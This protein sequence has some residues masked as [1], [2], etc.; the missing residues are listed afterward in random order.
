MKPQN[1]YIIDMYLYVYRSYFARL[2]KPLLSP[3]GE[4]TACVYVFLKT[5]FKL[6]KN[7]KPDMLVVAADSIGK[8]FRKEAYESYKGSRPETM[9]DD[10]IQQ[11][12][13]LIEILG[14]MDIPVFRKE[15]FEADDIIG[16]IVTEARR[17]DDGLALDLDKIYICTAD[18][19]MNQ[20]IVENK[21]LC[22]DM[23]RDTVT[24]PAS[25]IEKY[26]IEPYQFIE[27]LALSGDVSDHVPGV[28]GIG[29]KTAAALLQD[30]GDMKTAYSHI[31]SMGTN[32]GKKLREGRKMFDL[33]KFLV[34]IKTDVPIEI[35]WEK[36]V[37]RDFEWTRLNEIFC[38]LGMMSLVKAR[39]SNGRRL[40]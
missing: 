9:P 23:N 38:D 14:I 32:V 5:L 27:Y 37:V 36:A 19:D 1:L 3:D 6:L 34:T 39:A 35:D 17:A 15:G 31:S 4:P 25:V 30:W 29:P 28:R 24:G 16:T 11:I 18:K 7:R 2:D 20:L 12:N 10:M 8:T 21:V 33:S 22:Y 26:G 13:R 40:F